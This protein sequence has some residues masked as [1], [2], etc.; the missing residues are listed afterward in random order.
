MAAVASTAIG[1]V[2]TPEQLARAELAGGDGQDARAA[3]DVE[4][5]GTPAAGRATRQAPLVGEGLQR[6]QAQPRG[7]MKARPEGHARVQRQDHVVG[8]AAGGAA[9]SAG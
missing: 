1:S 7:G 8:T 4:D 2:S 3:A 9:T 6:G 5:T